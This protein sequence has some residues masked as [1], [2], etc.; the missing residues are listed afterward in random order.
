MKEVAE[1]KKSTSFLSLL[2]LLLY[3]CLIARLIALGVLT[4]AAVVELMSSTATTINTSCKTREQIS[5]CVCSFL[6]HILKKSSTQVLLE[7]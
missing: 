7:N 4:A 5:E 6:R 1:K 3:H 2:L